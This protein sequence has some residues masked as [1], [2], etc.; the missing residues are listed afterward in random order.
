MCCGRSQRPPQTPTGTAP[1]GSRIA[2]AAR[3]TYFQY[4]GTGSLTAIGRVTGRAYHF[5]VAGAT[6]K[7]DPRD[8]PGIAAVPH[9]IAVDAP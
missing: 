4:V 6:I 1:R 5:P 7:A 2:H 3:G 9:V 8:A